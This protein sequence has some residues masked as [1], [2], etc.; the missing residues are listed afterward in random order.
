[1]SFPDEIRLANKWF[2]IIFLGILYLVESSFSQPILWG[3]V[4]S[5]Y[6]QNSPV[7]NTLVR[8]FKIDIA[9]TDTA[10]TII[11]STLTDSSGRFLF[12][13]SSLDV[14]HGGVPYQFELSGNY[15]NPFCRETQLEFYLFND[16]NFSCAVYNV[17]GQQIT[18]MQKAL[19]R[20]AY[21]IRWE[22]ADLPGIY[23]IRVKAGDETRI[24]KSIQLARGKRDGGLAIL[25]SS[26][27]GLLKKADDSI[28]GSLN[29]LQLIVSKPFHRTYTSPVLS[30]E[31]QSLDIYLISKNPG[32]VTDGLIAYYPL[33]GDACDYSGN[34]YDG[35]P[36][37]NVAYIDGVKDKCLSLDGLTSYIKFTAD[38]S[39][40]LTS[41]YSVVFW[42]NT[43][44][45]E[46]WI[47]GAKEYIVS[48]IGQY[49]NFRIDDIELYC[50]V[51]PMVLGIK[52][53]YI[54][55]MDQYGMGF[56]RAKWFMFTVSYAY[57]RAF[58][59]V[60]SLFLWCHLNDE[61]GSGRFP[62]SLKYRTGTT[63]ASLPFNIGSKNDSP[64]PDTT[65][66]KGWIDEIRIYNR[67]LNEDEIKGIYYYYKFGNEINNPP[68]ARF[69]VTPTFG[70]VETV[71]TFD[72]STSSD[73]EEPT[74]SLQVR[75]DW[76]SDGLWDTEFSTEKIAVRQYPTTGNKRITLEVKDSKG[77]TH[78]KAVEISITDFTYETSTV[79]DIDG[80]VYK[81][82]KIGDQWWMAENLKVTHYRNGDSIPDGNQPI[83]WTYLITGAYCSYNKNTTYIAT[84]GLLYNWYAVNDSRNIS[85]V[86][87]HVAS[88][89]DWQT[90]V[91]HLGG[92]EV[93][94]GKMKEAGTI[95]WVSPNA[96]A[97]NESGFTALAGGQCSTPYGLFFGGGEWAFFWTSSESS[98]GAN[99]WS[100]Y[101][102]WS[103]VGASATSDKVC[104]FSVRCVKD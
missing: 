35:I 42:A 51:S 97:T 5:A 27:A 52:S 49:D 10:R 80:N 15:P 11:D 40:F 75:W 78:T 7:E 96:G 47:Y 95:H 18:S 64:Q 36:A 73:D 102:D 86:G 101:T 41:I 43:R 70:T 53:Q 68:T 37:G 77:I 59:D 22:G 81:T 57:D 34:G 2:G 74:S 1:M 45:I 99:Y 8:A 25:Q 79:A 17:L 3:T 4:K 91:D 9:G 32:V 39:P 104:G 72:A 103:K 65:R 90:L 58:G 38:R 54:G 66:F 29:Q 60:N 20:G 84:Y 85:P 19:G 6:D 24:V 94:G 13:L 31:S 87:W 88:N 71:F 26:R 28:S 69:T 62:D 48:S 46:K 98:G 16:G 50:I 55:G 83:S 61:G 12:L 100:L 82:V 67:Y 92:V 33:D 23:F 56:P 14:D 44:G 93:A 21:S 89:S 30:Y 76:E 63:I